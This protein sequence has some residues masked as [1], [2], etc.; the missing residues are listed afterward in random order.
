MMALAAAVCVLQRTTMP[1]AQRV[2]FV[3]SKF[4]PTLK[5]E[6]V[7]VNVNKCII[8]LD[9]RTPAEAQQAARYVA[10][11]QKA[12]LPGLHRALHVPGRDRLRAT[13]RS[14]WPWAPA[15]L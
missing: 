7:S 3:L 6:G 13:A 9:A 4:I 8:T 2:A 12:R 1:S 10:G 11:C 14:A 15:C 5:K